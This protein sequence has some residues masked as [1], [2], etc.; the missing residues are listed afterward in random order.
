MS[1]T[2][3]IGIGLAIVIV[4]GVGY[5]AMKPQATIAPIPEATKTDTNT[6]AIN[7]VETNTPEVPATQGKKMAFTE[8]IKQG[9]SYKCSVNQNIQNMEMKGTVYI[10]GALV[11]GDYSMQM[12]GMDMNS[13]M[14]VRDGYTYTWSSMMPTM[15]YKAKVIETLPTTDPTTGASGSYSWNADQIGDYDCAPWTKD[16]SVFAIPKEIDF[17]EVS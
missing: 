15:G 3:I 12:E 7:Q 5:L 8:F 1:S 11:R 14:V 2:K 16:D 13:Y 4:I 10:S 9:G 17:K 6:Q